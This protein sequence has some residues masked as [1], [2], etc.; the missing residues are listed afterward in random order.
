MA[1][2]SIVVDP[3]VLYNAGWHQDGECDHDLYLDP[4]DYIDP[5]DGDLLVA[6]VEEMHAALHPDVSDIRRCWSPPCA[7]LRHI[8][9][10]SR[11]LAES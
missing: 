7:K 5:A 11:P 9:P 3:D 2:V 4:G 1:E 6:A 8:A 10:W